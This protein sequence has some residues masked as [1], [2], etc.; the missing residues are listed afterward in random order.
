MDV[1]SIGEFGS[2]IILRMGKFL[3]KEF[4]SGIILKRKNFGKEIMLRKNFGSGIMLTIYLIKG[5]VDK[6]FGSKI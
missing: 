3:D 2:G 5:I 1:G 4:G 6:D